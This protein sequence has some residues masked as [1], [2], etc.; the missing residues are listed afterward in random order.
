MLIERKGKIETHAENRVENWKQRT[1]F[2]RATSLLLRKN[3]CATQ[4]HDRECD[5]N[6]C[7]RYIMNVILF[8]V[9]INSFFFGN[10]VTNLKMKNMCWR[11]LCNIVF[12]SRYL[13][14]I[15][16]L[17]DNGL[18]IIFTIF[19]VLSNKVKSIYSNYIETIEIK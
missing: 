15:H 4:L 1:G 17:G 8:L 14:K 18:S 3:L 2:Q 9:L 13:V 12:I 11:H 10:A 5:R 6:E 16:R 7:L 19:D